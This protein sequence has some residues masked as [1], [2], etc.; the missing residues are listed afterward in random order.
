[1]M[2]DCVV[3]LVAMVLAVSMF[4]WGVFEAVYFDWKQWWRERPRWSDYDGKNNCV[5]TDSNGA[6]GWTADRGGV[7]G[8]K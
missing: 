4:V 8:R 7:V 3:M 1:M 6:E 5:A 2:V